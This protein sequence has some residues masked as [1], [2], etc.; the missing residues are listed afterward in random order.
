MKFS[1]DAILQAAASIVAG[2]AQDVSSIANDDEELELQLFDTIRVIQGVEAAL[3]RADGK[4]K[5]EALK[6]T[7]ER[8]KDR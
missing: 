1:E 8:L 6:G 5:V 2:R 4:L 3:S 7:I